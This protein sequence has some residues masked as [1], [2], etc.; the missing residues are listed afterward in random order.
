M[1]RLVVGVWVPS[2]GE[3]V[4]GDS[5]LGDSVGVV[6]DV[7]VGLLVATYSDVGADEAGSLAAADGPPVVGSLVGEKV[8]EGVVG[9]CVSVGF[10]VGRC[11]W[12]PDVGPEVDGE[13]VGSTDGF[14]VVGSGLGL[15]VGRPVGF[16][17]GISVVE[18]GELVEAATG[19]LVVGSVALG[20]FDGVVVGS[21]VGADST[22]T[23][24][25]E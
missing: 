7:A 13:G 17:V 21:A 23:I 9:D 19:E 24:D 15:R 16:A 14:R 4:V 5:V 8:G 6:V 20:P 2:L 1:G 22:S 10:L 25:K 11:V 18:V 12:G 3:L